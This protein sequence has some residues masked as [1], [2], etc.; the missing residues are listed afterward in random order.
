VLLTVTAGYPD[1]IRCRSLPGGVVS[2]KVEKTIDVAVPV[3]T[4]YNQW[5][6]FEE[7]RKCGN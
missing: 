3:R 1:Y 5:T 2:T 4:A 6:Q 7:F